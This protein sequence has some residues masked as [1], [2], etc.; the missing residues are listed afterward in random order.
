V[1]NAL[2]TTRKTPKTTKSSAKV[3]E[4]LSQLAVALGVSLATVNLWRTRGAPDREERGYSVEAYRRWRLEHI[5][6]P[7]ARPTPTAQL[8]RKRQLE[9]QLL[10]ARAELTEIQVA[11]ARGDLIPLEEANERIRGLGQA[12]TRHLGAM[13]VKL[14]P[15]LVGLTEREMQPIIRRFC[16]EFAERISQL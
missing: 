9:E 8:S 6:L 14:A 15:L 16:R 7:A 11:R 12:M 10:A 3:V 2:K 4:T 1:A 13:H 5:K